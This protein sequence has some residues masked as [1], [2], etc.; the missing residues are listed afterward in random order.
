MA[1]ASPSRPGRALVAILVIGI[2]L[3]SAPA[4]FQMFTRAPKGGRM[5]EQFRPYM[6]TAKIGRFQGYLGE[7]GR[8][9]AEAQE[10][11]APVV[12]SRLGLSPAAAD[13]RFAEVAQLR[14]RWP[15]I[16]ADMSDMLAK[17]QRN[18]GKFKGVDALPPFVLFPWFFVLPGLLAAALAAWALAAR[19]RGGTPRRRVR[20]LAL[21]GVALIAAP[22]VFQMFSRAPG[23]ARMIDDFEPLMTTRK[24]TT[25]QGYF[26]VLGAAEGQLRTEVLPALASGPAG[27]ATSSAQFPALGAFSRDWPRISNEMA[28]MIGTMADNVDNYAAVRALPPFWLFPWFF[29]LPGLLIM[30]LAIETSRTMPGALR[31]A[32]AEVPARR[33]EDALVERSVR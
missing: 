3:A 24:V 14:Q 10:R 18:I 30:G 11:L 2:G 20:A 7:I 12:S 6:T 13:T 29:V 19:R 23:G 9:D 17:M 32:T 28:P 25:V 33:N 27:S 15:G 1:R 22:A 31:P 5:I 26:L 21:L 8:A 16:D 4:A